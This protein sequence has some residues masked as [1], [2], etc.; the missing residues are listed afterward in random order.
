MATV[1]SQQHSWASDKHFLSAVTDPWYQLLVMIQDVISSSTYGFF[2]RNGL[3]TLHLPITTCSI[4]SPMGLGSDSQP[5]RIDLFGVDVYLADSMQFMLEYGCRLH[6]AGCYYVMP[7]FRGD[8]PDESHLSQFYHCEAEIPCDLDRMMGLVEDYLRSMSAQILE[9][10]GAEIA[11]VVGPVPH[12]QQLVTAS[13]PIPQVTFDDA[14]TLLENRPEWVSARPQGFRVLTRAGEKA[15][16]DHFGGWVWVTEPDHIAVP[17]YQAF[18]DGDGRKAKAADLLC[19]LGEMV[20]SGERHESAADVR[21]ALAKHC[22]DPGPYEWYITLREQF[23]MQT[24]GFGLGTERYIC[25]LLGHHDVRDCQL[26]PRVNG[27][28]NIP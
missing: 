15:L 22:V 6:R 27:Q 12:V 28:I 26:L 24:S 19:G 8:S 21:R 4:S 23:P 25:W 7:S 10:C 13:R 2:S 1:R 18:G 17:F 9:T 20:G 11:A 5:V 3:R 16:I 14:A